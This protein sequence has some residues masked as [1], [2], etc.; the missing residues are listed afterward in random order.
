MNKIDTRRYEV[1]LAIQ[2]ALL[3]EVSPNLRAV[4]VSYTETSL[5]FEAYFDGEVHDEE[6]EAMSL[7]ETELM[8]EF[9]STHSLSHQVIRLDTPALIPKDR[10]WVYFRKEPLF[11]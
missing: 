11:E 9:P 10:T 6:R 8:A 4:T 2:Q 5:H 7:V 3:G 1:L